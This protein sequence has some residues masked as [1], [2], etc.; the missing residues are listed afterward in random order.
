VTVYPDH[1]PGLPVVAVDFDGT[2]AEA[3]WPSPRLGH[4]DKAAVELI[5]HYYA[6]GCQ[7]IV[8]TARPP[9]HFDRIWA[10]LRQ[11]KIAYAV[12]DVTSVKPIACLYFD[13]R[14]VRWPLT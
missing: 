11:H 5:E 13:D 7:I 3:T 12:Y 2:L 14:A 8:F 1:D 9:S 6:E 4:A 10:W